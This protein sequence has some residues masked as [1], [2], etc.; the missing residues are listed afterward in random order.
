M[1]AMGWACEWMLWD[2]PVNGCYG[3]AYKW[4]LWGE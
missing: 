1:D 4:M 3:V 2:G